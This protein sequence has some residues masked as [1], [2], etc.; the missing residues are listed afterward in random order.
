MAED[1]TDF[2][3]GDDILRPPYDNVQFDDSET[4]DVGG[5]FVP[6]SAVSIENRNSEA[7]ERGVKRGRGK[8]IVKWGTSGMRERVIWGKNGVPL[9][10]RDKCGQYSIYLGNLAAD[11]GYFP[12]NVKDWRHFEE[13]DLAPVWTKIEG[14]IDWSEAETAAKKPTIKKTAFERLA[15]RWKHHKAHLKKVYW[16]K[17]KGKDSRFQCPDNSLDPVQWRAFVTH[18]DDENTQVKAD[19]NVSNRS[20]RT[21]HHS[22][23]TRTFAAFVHEWK[24]LNGIEGEPDRIEIFKLTHGKKGKTNEYVDASS[25]NAVQRLERAEEERRRLNV[26]ITPKIREDIYAEVLGPEKRNRVRG[27]GAGVRWRDVPH[28]HTEKKS[29]SSTVE[30][31][32]ALKAQL[33]EHRLET[34]RLKIEADKEREKA[35]ERE[36]RMRNET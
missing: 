10:P 13:E 24:V 6:Q 32:K 12:I 19:I 7:N 30:A 35:A 36:E 26:E 28:I 22:T 23:G 31:L 1:F 25:A 14:T 34:E 21:M 8:T 15:D 16:L 33:E 20:Q 18:L 2:Q 11:C 3:L 27:L 17:E 4:Q 5:L 9:W 29:I